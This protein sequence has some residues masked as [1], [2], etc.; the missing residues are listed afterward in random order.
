MLR[1]ESE[2]GED[3]GARVDGSKGVAPSDEEHVL[4]AVLVRRVVAA[5]ADDG[6]EREAV[7]VEDLVGRVQPHRRVDQFVQL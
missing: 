4:D 1:L 7:G 6:A 5:E 2:D 3:D